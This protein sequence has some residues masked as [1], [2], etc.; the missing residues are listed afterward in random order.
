V[1]YKRLRKPKRGRTGRRKGDGR[2]KRDERDFGGQE[3]HP[4][5]GAL[6]LRRHAWASDEVET[7]ASGRRGEGGGNSRERKE[8][9]ERERVA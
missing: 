1:L 2:G 8:E 4:D 3:Q 7:K 5:A 6:S 9:R